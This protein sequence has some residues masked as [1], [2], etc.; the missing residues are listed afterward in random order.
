[1]LLSLTFCS[2][3]I[4]MVSTTLISEGFG[5]VLAAKVAGWSVLAT[6]IS[7]QVPNIFPWLDGREEPA[8]LAR[9]TPDWT[10]FDHLTTAPITVHANREH[11]IVKA[12]RTVAEMAAEHEQPGSKI[13]YVTTCGGGEPR[14]ANRLDI[15]QNNTAQSC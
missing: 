14:S 10:V 2:I 11:V 13:D 15:A 9:Q 1:M 6:L 12:P 5:K 7:T 3:L 4:L 8:P